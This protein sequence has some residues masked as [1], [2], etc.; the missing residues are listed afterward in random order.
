[1]STPEDIQDQIREAVEKTP[2]LLFM[3][4]S[5]LQPQC[6]FSARVV[7]VL[8]RHGVPYKSVDVLADPAVREGIKRFASWPT[9]PQLYAGGEFVGG[10]DIVLELEGTGELAE[11]LRAAVQS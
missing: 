9:V 1:V 10:C 4:G 5:P 7:Q 8:E 2:V 3:K 11:I 6:G